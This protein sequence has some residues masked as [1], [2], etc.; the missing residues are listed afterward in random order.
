VVGQETLGL[1]EGGLVPVEFPPPRWDD[2]DLRYVDHS[3]AGSDHR[4]GPDGDHRQRRAARIE[5]SCAHV[6]AV[7]A[8]GSSDERLKASGRAIGDRWHAFILRRRGGRR[9]ALRTSRLIRSTIANRD[10]KAEP[11]VLPG[12]CIV[13]FDH[14]FKAG[15]FQCRSARPRWLA[16]YQ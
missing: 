1:V 11:H 8:T 7:V 13:A 4:E 14:G 6:E 3:S 10:T 15:E 16:V 2:A 5:R 9:T 12:G